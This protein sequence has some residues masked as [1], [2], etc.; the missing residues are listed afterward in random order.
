M[1][2][3][4]FVSLA[5]IA[6]AL[7]VILTLVVLVVSI[8][9]NT[10]SQRSV[11]VDSLAAAIASINVQLIETPERG[12]AIARAVMDWNTVTREERVAAHFFL[13]SLFKLSENAWYQH[14]QGVL[15]DAQWAGW[16]RML[17]KYYHS[18]GIRESWW[19]NR[20]N[21][22]SDAFQRYLATT[23]SPAD[24]GNLADLFDDAPRY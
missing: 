16:E 5:E 20:R 3:A 21:A 11:A 15:D 6:N 18:K 7:A 19:P 23:T 10:K 9:Q 13:F 12:L 24:F 17:C 4:S 2:L 14:R 1:N 8:R 22:F